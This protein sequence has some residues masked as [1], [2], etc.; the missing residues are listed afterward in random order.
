MAASMFPKAAVITGDAE[1]FAD[2]MIRMVNC[3]DYR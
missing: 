2:E 1:S 3:K